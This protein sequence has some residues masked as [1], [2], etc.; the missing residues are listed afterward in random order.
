MKHAKI[1]YTFKEKDF[2]KAFG[3]AVNYYLD[4]TKAPSGRT[5]AEPRGF[6][7]VLDAFTRGKLVEIGV[8]KILE[9]FQNNKSYLLDFEIKSTREVN[10]EPDIIN[11]KENN[12]E[13]KPNLFIEI[14]ST[15]TND[16]WIGLTE[17]Q[18]ATMKKASGGKEI[19]NIYTNLCSKPND[20]SPRSTDFVGMYLKHI[21]GLSIFKSFDDLNAFADLEFIISSKELEKYGT[22]FQA[23]RL[24]YETNL[25]ELS[26]IRRSD[27]SL[28]NGI[29]L[30]S[31]HRS[32]SGKIKV[33]RR[34]G[35]FDNSFGLFDVSGSFDQY[36]KNNP[37]TQT[38]FI[39]CITDTTLK[40][41]VFGKFDLKKGSAYR[42]NLETLGRDPILKRNN[43]FIAK[44][45]IYQLINL[46]LIERPE[47][48][49]K[50]IAEKI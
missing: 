33:P 20:K 31:K 36:V 50:I 21:S 9:T 34:D 18:L 48:L 2:E 3:F 17:E 13:R 49:M 23:G 47:K 37:K 28:K 41:D 27:G 46:G 5:S 11:I 30:T 24:I 22:K 35:T 6:G 16:R 1:R 4:P 10:T 44:R 45:H 19:I 7:A 38:N 39:E 26:S 25:F 43:L 14:K 12:I 32:F 8:Q 29:N 15:S 40:N 42:F